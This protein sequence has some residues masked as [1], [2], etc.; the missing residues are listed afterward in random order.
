[1]L[2]ALAA[3]FLLSATANAPV[4]S[5]AFAQEKMKA[6]PSEK[7]KAARAKT[8]ACND[9]WKDHKKQTGAKGSAAYRAFMKDC[10]AKK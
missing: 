6:A 3:V 2:T 4:V 8:K 10:R 5:P 1:M 9:A 7:Q